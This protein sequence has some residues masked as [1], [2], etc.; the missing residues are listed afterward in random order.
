[1]PGSGAGLVS[2]GPGVFNGQVASFVYDQNDRQSEVRYADGGKV[3][4]TFNAVGSRLKVDD[5]QRIPNGSG[6]DTRNTTY[7]YDLRDRLT[8]Q[9]N[10]DGSGLAYDYDAA[11]NRTQLTATYPDGTSNSTS[12]TFD[13]L[14]RLATVTAAEGVT[15]Y[16]Y[17][18][19]GNPGLFIKAHQGFAW[20]AG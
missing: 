10:P 7:T 17:D 12:Y 6:Y 18:E 5:Y 19:V 11:S 16:D 3:V 1:M 8:T 4:T 20:V 14:N 15:T 13:A 9:T 2:N